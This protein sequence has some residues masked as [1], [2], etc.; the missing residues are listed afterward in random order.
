V[1]IVAR[2]QKGHGVSLL[3]GPENWHG[4]PLKKGEQL[5]HAIEEIRARMTFVDLPAPAR[6]AMPRPPAPPAPAAMPPPAYKLGEEVATR[7]AYGTALAKLGGVN[8]RIVVLDGDTKNSTFSERFLAVHPERFFEGFIAEQNMV[9]TAVGLS[10]SG[11]VPF[12]S[13]FACFFT[14]AFDHIRM[15]AISRATLKLAGSHCGASIG[16][17]GPSQMGLEDIAMMRAVPD[18]VVLYPADAVATER[19]VETMSRDPGIHYL[20]LTRPKT[21]VLYPATEQFPVGGSKVLRRSDEDVVTIVAAGITLFE[22]LAAHG[23]LAAEGIRVRVLDAYSVK[24]IDGA[25]IAAAARETKGR[26]VVVEDHYF[27]GGLGDAVLNAVAG[28]PFQVAKLAVRE[29]P[30]SGKPTELLHAYRI[31]ADAIVEQVRTLL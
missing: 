16:E 20:R 29:I 21:P 25:G 28:Q 23:R 24:P 14:R 4:K 26:I 1:A 11:K 30:R 19:L 10:A 5:D 12:A 31:D 15:A 18:A 27:D 17:D 2:T 13:T 6:R 22:A 9:G 8:P 3:S 7:E